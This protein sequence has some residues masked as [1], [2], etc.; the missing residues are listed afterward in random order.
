MNPRTVHMA[1]R[2]TSTALAVLAATQVLLA[3]IFLSGH[4]VAVRWHMLTGFSMV[5][6]A[7]LM[8]IVIFLPGRQHR[9]SN[10]MVE[11]V[12]VPLA[13]AAQGVLGVFRILELHIPIGVLMVIGT[14]QIARF[15]WKTPLPSREHEA[16]VLA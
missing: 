12:M 11:A 5:V 7:L 13:I 16:E 1:L 8:S 3:G 2:G 15:A 9:P 4:Y 14:F 6:V 10:L